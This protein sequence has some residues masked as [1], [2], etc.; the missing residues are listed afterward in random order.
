MLALAEAITPRYR[1]L[2]LLAVFGSLRWGEL[3][4]L[5]RHDIDLD[6]QTIRIER[7]LA[8]Q[9]GGGFAVAPPKSDAGKRT[10]VMPLA[11]APIMRQ[12][13]QTYIATGPD[14]LI[15]TSAAGRPLRHANFR[16]RAWRPAL[17]AAGLPM[18]SPA[19]GRRAPHSC[20][21]RR[22]RVIAFNRQP[23]TRDDSHAAI[24]TTR[25]DATGWRASAIAC[26]VSAANALTVILQAFTIGRRR[27]PLRSQPHK[28]RLPLR[29]VI[30]AVE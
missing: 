25:R 16:T 10:V 2:V 20:H 15:F 30:C 28:P 19:P 7:Q 13:M 21:S 27:D 23:A 5:Q 4:G 3:A 24:Y 1:A 22:A 14:S 9:R 17:R 6:A 11:I 18:I 8:E 26:D 12:R 29:A